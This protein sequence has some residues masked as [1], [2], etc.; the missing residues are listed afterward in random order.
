MKNLTATALITAA[1]ASGGVYTFQADEIKTLESAIVTKTEEIQHL[2]D[3]K[4]FVT[5]SYLYSQA[6]SCRTPTIDL[7][8]VSSEEIVKAVNDTI[9][10]SGI[11]NVVIDSPLSV[12]SVL[13]D[14]A[15]SKK[16]LICP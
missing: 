14:I 9:K 5:K 11:K 8:Y 4:N 13:Q 6:S 3:S 10:E 2:K 12:N 16:E 7:T 1:L 15:S